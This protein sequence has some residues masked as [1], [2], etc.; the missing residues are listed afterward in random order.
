MKACCNI[1]KFIKEET[2]ESQMDKSTLNKMLIEK[3]QQEKVSINCCGGFLLV[4]DDVKYFI[5]FC[6]LFNSNLNCPDSP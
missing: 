2:E 4:G 6:G 1:E 3:A 5:L